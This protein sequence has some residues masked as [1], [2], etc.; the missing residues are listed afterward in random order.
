MGNVAV[1]QAF[2]CAVC[3]QANEIHA[4]GRGFSYLDAGSGC[5]AA[6]NALG[7]TKLGGMMSMV[8]NRIS[9][10][11]IIVED[12]ASAKG[13]NDL[14]HENSAYIVGRM[15]IPYRDKGLSIICVVLDAPQNA[16]SALSG[17]LGMLPG[18][19]TKTITT[20]N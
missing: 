2:R 5:K 20:K 9:V 15:G 18:V 3:V 7:S 6:H 10:I 14:L 12:L 19:S 16:I 13:V 4:F 8:E 1:P 11:S 17:K